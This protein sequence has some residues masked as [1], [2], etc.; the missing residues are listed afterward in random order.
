MTEL[1]Q[2]MTREQVLFL[3]KQMLNGAKEDVKRDEANSLMIGQQP[4]RCLGC[5]EVH[6]NGV[7]DRLAPRVNHNCLPLGRPL[8]P[9]VYPYC[10]AVSGDGKSGRG[11]LRPL[12]PGGRFPA[13][14]PQTSFDAVRRVSRRCVASSAHKNFSSRHSR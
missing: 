11:P 6:P 9:A 4:C 1:K 8:M 10:T 12:K 5:G 7:N 3:V 13:H 14:R 2:R